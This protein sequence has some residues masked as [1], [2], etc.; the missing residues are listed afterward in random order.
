LERLAR[1]RLGE[2]VSQVY[3]NRCVSVMLTEPGHVAGTED[4]FP[5]CHVHPIS[6]VQVGLA[7]RKE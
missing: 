5:E 4:L 1:A 6:P 2:R 3:H 7:W